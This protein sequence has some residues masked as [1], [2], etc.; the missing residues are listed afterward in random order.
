[1][2]LTSHIRYMFVFI[3]TLRQVFIVWTEGR[4][5][6]KFVGRDG[7]GCVD[8][9]KTLVLDL[10]SEQGAW[11]SLCHCQRGNLHA[12]HPKEC[13]AWAQAASSL[14]SLKGSLVLTLPGKKKCLWLL[15][16]KKPFE[17]HQTRDRT[18]SKLVQS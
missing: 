12:K 10:G 14:G 16:C 8:L 6:V 4:G 3:K 2:G 11:G 7:A 1:M 18:M 5:R 17:W 15:G 13:M 9:K